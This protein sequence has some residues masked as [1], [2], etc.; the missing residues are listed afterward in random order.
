MKTILIVEDDAGPLQSLEENLEADYNILV[1]GNVDLA[2]K[3]LI[4]DEE[5]VDLLITDW[6]LD[7]SETANSIIKMLKSDSNEKIATMPFIVYSSDEGC[8]STV[9]KQGGSY[10]RK[11]ADKSMILEAV[12]QIL[13]E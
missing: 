3:I 4:E 2:L 5:D 13:G 11:P 8:K 10:I 6:H 9:E 7:S 12:K 1:A